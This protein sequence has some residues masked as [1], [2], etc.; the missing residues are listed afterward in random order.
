MIRGV[1]ENSYAT[2]QEEYRAFL[3]K[4]MWNIVNGM[5]G[6]KPVTPRWGYGLVYQPILVKGLSPFAVYN[7]P[8]GL[9]MEPVKH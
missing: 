2:I 8:L 5:F 7:A 1:T 4:I 9:K 3:K 6:I